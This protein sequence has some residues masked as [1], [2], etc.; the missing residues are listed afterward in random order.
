MQKIL[1]RAL[2]ILAF[3]SAMPAMAA[4]IHLS[5]DTVDFYYDDSSPEM[6]AYESLSVIGNTI[7]ATPS[8]FL[9]ESL[10]G[11]SSDF[12]AF[13]VVNVVAK[14]GYRFDSIQVAQQGDYELTGAGA[15]VNAVG[16]L[17]V[18]ESVGSTSVSTAMVNSGF[19]TYGALT[20][21]SS[22]AIIDLNNATWESIYSIDLSLDSSLYASTIEN[23]ERAFIQNKFV[24]GSLVSIETTPIPLPAALWL[25]ISGLFVF[26]G[27]SR[28]TALIK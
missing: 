2:G 12:T 25:M 18:T 28:K 27:L 3:C 4:I 19:G 11:G 6:A 17:A 14:S 10:N 22:S 15:S 23:G 8:S 13:G 5:G 20:Q 16:T 21:W 9:A 26:A 1:T 24:G 7:F